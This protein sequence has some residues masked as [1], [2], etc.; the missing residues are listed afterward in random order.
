ME[1]VK[2]VV[3]KYDYIK[4]VGIAG[5]GTAGKR[6]NVR[7]VK[8]ASRAVSQCHQVHQYQR[9]FTP[10]QDRSAPEIRCRQHYRDPE[11]Y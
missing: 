10:G 9:T 4:V 6:G 5:P 2:K 7:N 11:C 8:A 3:D 1:M